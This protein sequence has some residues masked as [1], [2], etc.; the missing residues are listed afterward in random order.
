[1]KKY[2]LILLIGTVVALYTT[3]VIQNL[4]NWYA[5]SALHVAEVPFWGMYGLV[6]LIGLFRGKNPDVIA[7]KRWKDTIIALDACIPDV[8]RQAVNKQIEELTQGFLL[9]QG[10]H[11]FEVLIGNTFVLVLGYG[12]HVFLA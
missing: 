6:L 3:F 2:V 5:T 1:M 7:E 10:M 8:K 11:V 12:V 4:W 9:E